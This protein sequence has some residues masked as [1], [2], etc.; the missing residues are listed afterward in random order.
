MS[1]EV[2]EEESILEEEEHPQPS[3]EEY[4]NACCHV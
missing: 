1:I 2:R 3:E 4:E